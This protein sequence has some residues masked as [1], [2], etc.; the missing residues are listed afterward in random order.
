MF[1]RM[2]QVMHDTGAAWVYS[3]STGHPRIDYQ[4]GSIRDNFD[5]GAVV[6]V[7]TKAVSDLAECRWGGLYDLRLRI[8]EKHP[9][10][11]EPEPPYAASVADTRA[12]GQK[13]FDYVDPR[14]GDYQIEM[15]AIATERVKRIGAWLE[16]RFECMPSSDENFPGRASIVIP[17]R[18]RERTILDAVQSA[19]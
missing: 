6:A 2:S 8:S 7:K 18:N 11:R 1:E 3:D 4:R 12:S 19:L 17:V 15:E 5:F 13:Q 9:I 10:V 16:P 14:N